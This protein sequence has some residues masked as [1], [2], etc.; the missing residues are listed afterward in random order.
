MLKNQDMDT[1][2]H[3][4]S[5]T[6]LSKIDYNDLCDT[7]PETTRYSLDGQWAIIQYKNIPENSGLVLWTAN[8]A[9]QYIMDNYLEWN[10]D[11]FYTEN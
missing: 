1:K 6:D 2:Y 9:I 7:S 10:D 11:P 5:T 3:L 4:I 8:E